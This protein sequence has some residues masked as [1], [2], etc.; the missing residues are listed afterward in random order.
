MTV[1]TPLVF[2]PSLAQRTVSALLCAGS[3]IVGLRTLA[4]LLQNLPRLHWALRQ[5][6]ATG[7]PTAWLWVIFVSAIAACL[8]GG[9]LLLLSVLLLVLVEGSQ[10]LVDELGISVDLG[11]LPGFLTR[12]LGAGR[13]VWKDITAIGKKSFFFFIKG[14]ESPGQ[15]PAPLPGSAPVLRFLVV[16]ELERLVLLILERSPN[17]RFKE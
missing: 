14:A 9:G 4:L 5:A 6:Q 8:A 11:G 16:D 10:V 17:L 7:E 3:W 1:S 13:L 15:A 2:R 12:R